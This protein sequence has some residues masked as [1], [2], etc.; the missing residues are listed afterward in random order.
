MIDEISQEVGCD[1]CYISTADHEDIALAGGWQV[2]LSTQPHRH[3]C[4][5]CLAVGEDPA[6]ERAPLAQTGSARGSGAPAPSSGLPTLGFEGL[7]FG[8]IA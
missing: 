8:P 1:G 2:N 4:P 6:C 5:V 7:H 3:I